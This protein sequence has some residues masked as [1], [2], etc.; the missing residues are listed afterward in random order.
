M[1]DE[2]RTNRSLHAREHQRR[3]FQVNKEGE[4]MKKLSYKHMVMLW[5]IICKHDF[6]IRHLECEV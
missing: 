2:E 1:R 4:N 3:L 5:A 6:K